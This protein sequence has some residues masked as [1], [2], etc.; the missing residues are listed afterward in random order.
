MLNPRSLA[1]VPPPLDDKL[2]QLR[3]VQRPNL[4]RVVVGDAHPARGDDPHLRVLRDERVPKDG[5]PH[6]LLLL[7]HHKQVGR[8]PHADG[9]APV[10][11]LHDDALPLLRRK[12][13]GAVKA[14]LRVHNV[15]QPGAGGEADLGGLAREDDVD[16]LGVGVPVLRHGDGVHPPCG[17]AAVGVDDGDGRPRPAPKHVRLQDVVARGVEARHVLF[18]HVRG[19]LDGQHPLPELG[20]LAA[21]LVVDLVHAQPGLDL[22][23][24]HGEARRL[25]L[26]LL[27][28]VVVARAGDA[29]AAVLDDGLPRRC[30]AR[31]RRPDD[32][33]APHRE[34]VGD[35]GRAGLLVVLKLAC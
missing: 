24:R 32:P 9:G 23:Q 33:G 18:A 19:A 20:Q 8:P 16:G 11:V 3:R 21:V 15:P 14:E 29:D 17:D 10:G 25:E 28:E 22:L 1:G 13:P 30:R 5:R 26:P 4:R 12:E 31:R 6:P 27:E 34:R 35:G 2:E 7:A